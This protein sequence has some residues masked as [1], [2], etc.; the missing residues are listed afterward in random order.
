MFVALCIMII[1]LMTALSFM[2]FMLFGQ[3]AYGFATYTRTLSKLVHLLAGGKLFKKGSQLMESPFGLLFVML[4]TF[5]T[6]ILV[7]NIFISTIFDSMESAR[8]HKRDDNLQLK[9]FVQ[10]WFSSL[11]RRKRPRSI[12]KKG[13]PS[14]G[15]DYCTKYVNGKQNTTVLFNDAETFHFKETSL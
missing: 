8:H 6:S 1:I 13:A 3:F 12:Y 9:S 10:K 15:K 11:V 5:T 4:Y 7:L 2:A 14:Q